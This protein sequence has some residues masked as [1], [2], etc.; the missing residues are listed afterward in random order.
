MDE[1]LRME[2]TDITPEMAR[3]L[4]NTMDRNRPVRQGRVAE[5][6]RRMKN[7][8]W[9]FNADPIRISDK[10]VLIDGQHRLLAC[11]EAGVSFKALIV[12]GL[13]SAVFITLDNQAPR[14][15]GDDLAMDEVS[16][17]SVVAAALG[18]VW[19]YDK[20]RMTLSQRP[21]GAMRGTRPELLEFY[22]SC[23]PEAW[24]RASRVGYKVKALLG[25]TGLGAAC[26]FIF[27]RFSAQK[28]DEFFERLLTGEL[29]TDGS[30]FPILR[31]RLMRDMYEDR[32]TRL[33]SSAK[34]ALLF[35]AWNA[36][37][38][39]TEVKRLAITPKEREEFPVALVVGGN[40]K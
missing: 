13:P 17:Y 26:H 38:S 32:D 1:K 3:G 12:R 2:V 28:A 14:S 40:G 33:S 11:I 8:E 39:N 35:K 25:S 36:F 4:L 23:D 22:H 27:Q 10:G 5:W 15:L 18:W 19:L 37:I 20:G 29:S 30:P 7:G 16:N 21:V 31:K 24:N 34:M 6:V 9:Q